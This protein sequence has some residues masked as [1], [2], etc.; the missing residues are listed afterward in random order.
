MRAGTVRDVLE[1]PL[2]NLDAQ[3]APIEEDIR[4]AILDVIASKATP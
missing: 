3:C 4:R 2:V 1:V